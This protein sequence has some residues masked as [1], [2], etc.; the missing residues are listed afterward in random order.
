MSQSPGLFDP[1]STDPDHGPGVAAGFGFGAAVYVAIWLL[2]L[3][4]G[5]RAFP[6]AG[7][8]TYAFLNLLSHLL[9]NGGL[10]LHALGNNRKRFARG[11]IIFTALAFLLDSA[12]WRAFR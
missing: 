2:L 8:N 12:C 10:I 4:I 3:M 5:D 11:L 6:G 1:P 9:T 7:F